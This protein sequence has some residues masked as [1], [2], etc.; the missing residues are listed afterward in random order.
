VCGVILCRFI[1]K[2]A[3]TKASGQRKEAW[4]RERA[5]ICA[6][7]CLD[8]Q[9]GEVDFV[10]AAV[11]FRSACGGGASQHVRENHATF[12]ERHWTNFNESG[13]VA[14]AH[15]TGRP[16]IISEV[17]AL[18]A[19]AILKGGRWV[20]V[21]LKGLPGATEDRL[22]YYTTLSEALADSE[23]LRAI[24]QKYDCTPEALLRHMHAVDP[25]LIRITLTAH[26]KFS[27]QE[28]QD[29]IAWTRATGTPSHLHSLSISSR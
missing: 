26:H 20:E 6:A 19:A 23:P 3:K 17:D 14:D 27:I 24:Q 11:N 9:T 1:K 28:L 22:L 12:I 10:K 5:V 13:C 15:R 7:S 4:V 16:P 2:N 25:D 8:F 21:K 29:R 18:A